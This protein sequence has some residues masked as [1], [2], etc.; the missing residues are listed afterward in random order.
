M[1]RTLRLAIMINVAVLLSAPLVHAQEQIDIDAA[2]AAQEFRFGVLSFHAGRFNDAIVAF[3]RSLAFKP[4]DV[5]TREW[6]GRAYFQSGFEDAALN[7]W[8]LVIDEG[9]AGAYLRAFYDMIEYRR[10]LQ[11]FIEPELTLN[12]SELIPAANDE[13]RFFQRPAGVSSDP[14]GRIYVVSLATQEILAFNPN[15]RII[16]RYRGGIIGLD[17]PMDVVWTPEGLYVTEFGGDRISLL[18]EQG[19]R[20]MSFGETGLGDGSLLGPQFLAVDE[21]GFIWVTEWGNRRASKFAS[22]GTFILTIGDRRG[23]RGQPAAQLARPTGIAVRD[24]IVYVADRDDDGVAIKRYDDSGNYLDRIPLPLNSDDAV[25]YG[26]SG[27]IVEDIEWF[28]DRR[29]AIAVSDR[30]LVFDPALEQ[31]VTEVTDQARRRVLSATR[32]ANGRLIVSDFDADEIGIFEPTHQLYGGV[33]VRIERVLNRNFPEVSLL[34]SVHDRDGNPLIGLDRRN[35]VVTELGRLQPETSVDVAISRVPDPDLNVI[36]ADRNGQRYSE[37]AAQGIR[38]L[39]SLFPDNSIRTVYFAAAS[40]AVILQA[41][42]SPERFGEATREVLATES[43][44]FE[45]GER[46]L[47]RTIRLATTDLI[48]RGVRRELVLFSDGRVGDRDFASMGVQEIAAYLRNNGVRLHIVLLEPGSVDDELAYL[49]EESAG[50]IRY[51]YEPA[52]LTTLPI[53]ISNHPSGRYWL[54]Y[55]S[56]ANSDFG[57][58]YMELDVEVALFIRSGRD[59]SG[60]FGPAPQ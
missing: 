50:T 51:L 25:S 22:D 18:N 10:G 43:G 42:A 4:E 23:T 24:G 59:R 53:E 31:V 27:A 16:N 5:R 29:L 46:A 49:V 38:D 17:Q 30:V 19:N 13:A 41:P 44:S 35:F 34:V 57:R 6:L 28:D 40:P 8:R 45:N 56:D 36:V 33:D 32:D 26:L 47:D 37:D 14:N 52:G 54:T 21:D 9:G 12:A 58:R 11:P 3:T 7:E 2:E 60:F 48:A 15:G 39:L 1:S 20:I 55:T